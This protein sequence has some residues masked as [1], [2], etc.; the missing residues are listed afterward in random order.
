MVLGCAETNVFP[1]RINYVHCEGRDIRVTRAVFLM[2]SEVSGHSVQ[3]VAPAY[4]LFTSRSISHD[5]VSNFGYFA[6]IC[7]VHS[8]LQALLV[9]RKHLS[10]HKNL[11]LTQ[12]IYENNT[13]FM[14]SNHEGSCTL[15]KQY[16]PTFALSVV[17]T[18]ISD[19]TAF[20]TI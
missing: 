10:A 15:V 8:L 3:W 13:C 12:K 4:S 6:K 20:P 14:A 1:E 17:T 18:L 2:V 16:T 7:M 9:N 11:P 19:L 5:P